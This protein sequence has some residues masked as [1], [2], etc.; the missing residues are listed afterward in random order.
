MEE[1]VAHES[2]VSDT[3]SQVAVMLIK[4]ESDFESNLQNLKKKMKF[5]RPLLWS[6]QSGAA[7]SNAGQS[8]RKHSENRLR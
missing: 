2:K 8:S 4:V 6:S 1:D 7:G 5:S 3:E